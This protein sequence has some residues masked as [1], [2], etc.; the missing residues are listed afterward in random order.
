V[1]RVGINDADATSATP[2]PSN[3]ILANNVKE[4][5]TIYL[6]VHPSDKY[7]EIS[8]ATFHKVS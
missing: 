7:V 4:S 2:D 1:E 6:R 3:N 5:G 8:G